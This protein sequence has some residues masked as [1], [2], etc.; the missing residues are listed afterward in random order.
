[1]KLALAISAWLASTALAQAPARDER[2]A[3]LQRTFEQLAE[4][5]L[6]G[7]VLVAEKDDVLL[8]A[9]CG[10]ADRAPARVNTSATIFDI[11]SITKQFT[12][13][14]ILRLEEQDQLATS[15]T[16]ERFFE[17]VPKDKQRI[18]LHHLLTHTS[19]LPP[20]VPVSSATT[21]R[22]ALVHAVMQAE[23]QAKP[24]EK[25][26]YNNVGYELLGAVVEIAS[27]RRFEQYVAEHLFAPAGLQS[28]GFLQENGIDTTRTAHGY[29][30][31][32]RYGP[33]EKAWYSWGLRGAGG[34]LSTTG[35]LLR[36]SRALE[37]DTVLSKRSRAKLF[38][39]YE[40]DYAYGWWVR[41]DARFG[42]VISHNGSTRGFEA[43]LAHY[44]DRD[45]RVIVLCND[46]GMRDAAASKLALA[47][48]GESKQIAAITLTQKQL[49][50]FAGE[51]EAS[52]GGKLR[53]RVDGD[54]LVLEPDVET[55]VGI[56][57]G[58]GSTKL[59]T[60]APAKKRAQKVIDLL[61]AGDAEAA[62]SVL[63]R[64]YPGWNQVMVKVWRD[65]IAT[66]GTLERSECLGSLDAST[67]LVRL[68]HERRSVV[69]T[70]MWKD[71]V[72]QAWSIDGGLPENA[73]YRPLT[74]SD[75]SFEATEGLPQR[76]TLAFE[77]DKA[78]KV[79]SLELSSPRVRVNAK[80][81]R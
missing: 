72:L 36:W 77:R 48:L 60:D 63:T 49:E 14:A 39:P 20:D 29:D 76:F 43:A 32:T 18:G 22:D 26:V 15:D 35:D 34:V 16:L 74:E 7:S 37:G 50:A 46:I 23:L 41:T 30:G 44:V 42:K 64:D 53:V 28:T 10:L 61:A 31:A 71:D 5:G 81:A 24:G 70:L 6:S 8:E 57:A 67:T 55:V 19:G 33:A 1:M 62:Q 11:G 27:K 45:V 75:F 47:A 66:R 54:A 65:W 59:A 56:V 3:A 58:G 78:G 73:H 12:A 80:R 79:L 40:L 69:W 25:F 2:V 68:V 17:G 21:E 9:A 52:L 4:S 38:T 51:Y 13:A